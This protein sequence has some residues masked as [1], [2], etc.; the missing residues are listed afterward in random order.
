MLIGV[1][2]PVEL[3]DGARCYRSTAV[4]DATRLTAPRTW[5]TARGC[6]LAAVA[7]DW[8]V[9]D[10][11]EEWTV[12]ADIFARTYDRLPDGRYAKHAT[13]DAVRTDRPVEVRTLE[14]PARAEPGDWVLRGV[15]GELWTVTD[16]YF[17]THYEPA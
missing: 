7:G 3:L 5:H 12:A 8:L 4:V 2:D 16:A 1:T 17:R 11:S 9:T 6:A 15:D 10:G 13:V 14:G